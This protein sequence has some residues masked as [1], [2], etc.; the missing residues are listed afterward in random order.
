MKKLIIKLFAIIFILA[1][2]SSYAID[3]EILEGDQDP[4][5]SYEFIKYTPCNELSINALST[6]QGGILAKMTAANS[7]SGTV[8]IWTIKPYDEEARLHLLEK[9]HSL[10]GIGSIK[11]PVWYSGD[12]TSCEALGISIDVIHGLIKFR[13]PKNWSLLYGFCTKTSSS[14]SEEPAPKP[15]EPDTVL[16]S[17]VSPP[18]DVIEDPEPVIPEVDIEE[19]PVLPRPVVKPFVSKQTLA[20]I[21]ESKNVPN[22]SDRNTISLFLFVLISSL[23]SVSLLL[24]KYLKTR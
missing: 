1:P 15:E 23:M 16:D 24:R 9:L 19:P 20:I 4:S 8:Y 10:P 5:N 7:P 18:D 2:V 21:T 14:E 17:P 13:S 6:S 11:N 3:S 12:D 22:T